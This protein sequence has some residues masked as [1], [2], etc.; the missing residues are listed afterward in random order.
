MQRQLLEYHVNRGAA[1]NVRS[2]KGREVG[3]VPAS[4]VCLILPVWKTTHM[5]LESLRTS[6]TTLGSTGATS[7][8]LN[9]M[10]ECKMASRDP[11]NVL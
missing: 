8:S 5:V 4:M 9:D 1:V 6:S 10:L 3:D 2:L 11:M 7:D